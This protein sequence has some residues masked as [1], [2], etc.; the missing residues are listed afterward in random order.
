MIAYLSN[1]MVLLGIAVILA[2]SLNL[3]VGYAGIFS[4]AH[5]VFYGVGAYTAAKVALGMTDSFLIATAAAMLVTGAV[6]FILAVPVLR[7]R[8]EYF[9]VASI[10]FQ[11]VAST[12]FTSWTVVTGGMGG[13]A[14]IPPARILGWQLDGSVDM[15]VL[16][17]VCVVLVVGL[18]A[19]LVHSPFGRALKAFRDDETAAIA[20]G[21]DPLVLRVAATTL[22]GA[23]AAVAG[24]IY[25]FHVS[26]VNPESFTLDYSVL[27]LA[28]VIIGGAGSLA[29]PI[30]GAIFITVF[31][32]LLNFLHLPSQYVGPLE[33]LIYGAAIVLLMVFWPSGL[34]NAW[35]LLVPARR[36]DV[37][38]GGER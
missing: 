11:I 6:S 34:A 31:P 12:I 27:V 25:A 29:G 23:L 38:A 35:R 14:G 8:E 32:A 22:S 36:G 3:M 4:V 17:G 1:L 20:L 28:M 9:V 10:G 5:A 15:M 13:L 18:I 33:Q 16:T 2:S 21:K 7:V 24:S 30:V 19:A 37:P 26:F